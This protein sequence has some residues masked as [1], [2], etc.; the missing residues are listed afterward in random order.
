MDMQPKRGDTSSMAQTPQKANSRAMEIMSLLSLDRFGG[1]SSR[2]ATP[3]R[4][5]RIRTPALSSRGLISVPKE[6]PEPPVWLARA[7][8]MAMEYRTRPTTSSKATTC[9]RVSTKS[10]LARVWRMVIMVEAG[11]VAEARAESTIEKDSSRCR[12]P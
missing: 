7:T 8:A 10:P 2:M 6:N 5:P 1:M 11:A 3:K 12:T 4:P 9:N